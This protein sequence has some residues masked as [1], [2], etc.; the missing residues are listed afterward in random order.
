[1]FLVDNGN[2]NRTLWNF[3]LIWIIYLHTVFAKKELD[4]LTETK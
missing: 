1:M 4:K 3:L 2:V